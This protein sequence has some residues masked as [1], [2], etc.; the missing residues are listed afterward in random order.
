VC[1]CV[2]HIYSQSFSASM[3]PISLKFLRTVRAELPIVRPEC[4]SFPYR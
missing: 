4:S 3:Y 1:V 2:C